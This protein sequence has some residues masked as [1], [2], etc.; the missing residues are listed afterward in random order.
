MEIEK[1]QTQKGPFFMKHPVYN[2]VFI[3]SVCLAGG[4]CFRISRRNCVMMVRYLEI[5]Y[6]KPSE[7]GL[8]LLPYIYFYNGS[9]NRV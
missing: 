9:V 4:V 7:K 6:I 2:I 5:K 1:L 3:I 8:L